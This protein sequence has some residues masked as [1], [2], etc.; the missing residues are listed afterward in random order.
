MSGSGMGREIALHVGTDY[1]RQRYLGR[2]LEPLGL[3]LH[4]VSSVSAAKK[5]SRKNRYRLVL[6]HVKI[7]N[8]EIL[9]FCSFVRIGNPDAIMIALMENT[10]IN[11]EEKLFDCGLNDVVVGKQASTRVLTKRIRAH[12]YNS[13]APLEQ[14]NI[15]RLK[16]V[17]VDF[18]RREV[19]CNGAMHRLPGILADL[20]KY[21]IDNPGRIISRD[22][23]LESPMWV[24][25]ICSS[26][27]EGGKT[28]DVSIGKLRKIIESDPAHP[29]LI[30]TVRGAGWK[31]AT[32]II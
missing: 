16:N 15:I 17:T 32:D 11:I 10:R 4:K 7:F 13:R 18:E 3:E 28:F 1:Q 2:Y 27:K 30:V 19:W 20:L 22:E 25:S 8:G 14:T 5:L 24:D 9:D 12:L 23:L 31:L 29:E 21:F 26:A 6:L